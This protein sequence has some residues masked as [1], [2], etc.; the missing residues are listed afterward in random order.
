MDQAPVAEVKKERKPYTRR[1]PAPPAAEVLA[2]PKAASEAEIL[3]QVIGWVEH[4]PKDTIA[5]IFASASA[6]C[7]SSAT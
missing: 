7:G 3:A 5:R 1:E 4:L 6:F 2:N